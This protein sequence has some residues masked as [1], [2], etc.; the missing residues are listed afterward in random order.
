MHLIKAL[1]LQQL[2]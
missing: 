1:A 2:Y